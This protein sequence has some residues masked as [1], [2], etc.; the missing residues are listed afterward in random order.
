M[1]RSRSKKIV[2][3]LGKK[4]NK[5]NFALLGYVLLITCRPELLELWLREHAPN[6]LPEI[7]TYCASMYLIS[8]AIVYIPS[9]LINYLRKKISYPRRHP[10]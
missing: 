5:S 8:M 6:F 9:I 2:G 1:D 4:A 10:A 3:W 7:V